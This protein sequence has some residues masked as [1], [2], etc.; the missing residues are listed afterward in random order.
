MPATTAAL[1]AACVMPCRHLCR[2]LN[3]SPRCC[4]R[5]LELRARA[6]AGQSL[7]PC[8]QMP[9][10]PQSLHWLRCRPC[11]HLNLTPA[12][13]FAGGRPCA[14]LFAVSLPPPPSSSPPPPSSWSPPSPSYPSPPPPNVT[15][16]LSSPGT[17]APHSPPCRS[18]CRSPC[19][20]HWLKA[21]SQNALF[22]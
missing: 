20:P 5:L 1:I 19:L 18:P 7:R 21:G 8:S 4:R 2:R 10:P 11:A 6:A 22:W 15:T 9:P 14:C 17:R 16:P 13:L 3:H 12:C